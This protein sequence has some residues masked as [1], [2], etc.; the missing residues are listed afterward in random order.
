MSSIGCPCRRHLNRPRGNRSRNELAARRIGDGGAVESITHPIGP[1][2][3]AEPL[4]GD[5]REQT[6]IRGHRAQLRAAMGE[7]GSRGNGA[8]RPITPRPLPLT[9]I[10]SASPAFSARPSWPPMLV[11]TC[12]ERLPRTCGN[13]DAAGHC[14]IRARAAQALAKLQHWHPPSLQSRDSSQLAHRPGSDEIL[15]LSPRT[16]QPPRTARAAPST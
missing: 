13:I 11:S 2:R 12:V 4:R 10:C 1:R 9:P 3:H 8:H 7:K 5:V 16:P 6:R 14:D 15:R